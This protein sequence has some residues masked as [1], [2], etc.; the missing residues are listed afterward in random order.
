M[1]TSLS[2]ANERLKRRCDRSSPLDG[3]RLPLGFIK[4]DGTVFRQ[5]DLADD[6]YTPHFS[7][8]TTQINHF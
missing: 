4:T 8:W 3:G 2:K 1:A 6:D 5:I 7:T